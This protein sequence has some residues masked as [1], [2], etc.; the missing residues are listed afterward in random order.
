M[1]GK[2]RGSIIEEWGLSRDNL[3]GLTLKQV[4][5]KVGAT[6]QSMGLPRC[7]WLEIYWVCCVAS[8]YVID[9]SATYKNIVRTE[10]LTSLYA[11]AFPDWEVPAGK[12]AYPPSI[13]DEE[14]IDYELRRLLGGHTPPGE[15]AARHRHISECSFRIFLPAHHELYEVLGRLKGRPRLRRKPGKPPVHSDRIAVRCAALKSSGMTYVQIAKKLEL[16]FYKY[17][18]SYQSDPVR[19]LVKRGRELMDIKYQN[20]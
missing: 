15:V 19:W 4:R 9:D 13:L 12:R 6:I 20:L 16:P 3:A 14:D 17:F 2:W 8:D 10:W 18:F 1:W 5:Q 11:P 7:L